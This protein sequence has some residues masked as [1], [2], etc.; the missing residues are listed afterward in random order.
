MK[1]HLLELLLLLHSLE[2]LLQLLVS[3]EEVHHRVIEKLF[4]TTTPC[5]WRFFL[6]ALLIF[7]MVLDGVR[8]V[9]CAVCVVCVLRR[10]LC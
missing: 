8:C 5:S 10:Q 7:A 2:L 4:C 1:P 6:F 9:C 3:N